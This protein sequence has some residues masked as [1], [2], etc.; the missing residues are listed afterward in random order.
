MEIILKSFFTVIIYISAIYPSFLFSQSEKEKKVILIDT[1][2]SIYGEYLDAGN[3]WFIRNDTKGISIDKKR[4]LAVINKDYYDLIKTKSAIKSSYESLVYF[5]SSANYQ[6]S[7]D[8][9]KLHNENLFFRITK[10]SFIFVTAY[11]Y[12]ESIKANEA[13][14]NSIYGFSSGAERR[15]NGQYR[16][17]QISASLTLLTFSYSAVFAYLRFGRDSKFNNLEIQNRQHIEIEDFSKNENERKLNA[18]HQQNYFEFAMSK[19]I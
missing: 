13:I 3:N 2:K 14:K 8:R 10:I 12:N 15:F 6:W 11:F 16:N 9:I 19:T 17:Y 5:D 7:E 1:D 4:V 18:N